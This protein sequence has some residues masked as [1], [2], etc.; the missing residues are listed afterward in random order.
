M[1][2]EMFL[3]LWLASYSDI[4]NFNVFTKTNDFF[5]RILCD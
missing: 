4:K 1:I 5:Y 3:E 2:I